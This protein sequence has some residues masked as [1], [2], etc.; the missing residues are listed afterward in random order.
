VAF[1]TENVD[2]L[3]LNGALG[4]DEPSLDFL[5]DMPV[6]ELE[7]RDAR[8][9]SQGLEPLYLLSETLAKLDLAVDTSIS[10]DLAKLPRLT[11]LSAT[12]RQVKAS[13]RYAVGLERLYMES[14][15][16][17]DLTPLTMLRSLA[18]LRMKDRP[19]IASLHGL[20]AMSSV[21][22][23]GI[24]VARNLADLTELRTRHDL[25]H[26][27]L[28]GCR[29]IPNISDIEACVGLQF[30]NLA[31]CGD[32]PTVAPIRMLTRLDSLWLY[33]DTKV[34][35]GDLTPVLALPRLEDFRMMSRRGYNPSV[36]EIERQILERKAQ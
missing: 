22:H 30:L 20:S 31:E 32:L 25:M 17:P 2:R 8:F 16:E 9:D 10:V 11:A 33:G 34:L 35:D 14:Y 15:G 29:K 13:I 28:E 23:L 26:L 3:I 19:R 6:R 18:E 1:E 21:R 27:E 5:R 4:F 7:I 36:S 12:W 24:F